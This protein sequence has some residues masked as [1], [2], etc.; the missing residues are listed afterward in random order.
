MT[1]AE[2][3]PQLKQAE[4]ANQRGQWRQAEAMARAYLESSGRDPQALMILGEALVGMRRAVEAERLLREAI[5]TSPGSGRARL[6]LGASLELQCRVDEAVELLDGLVKEQAG[7]AE[8]WQHFAQLLGRAFRF[9]LAIEAHKRVLRLEDKN[10]RLWLEYAIALRFAGRQADALS[11]LRRSLELDASYG[12]A[13]WVVATMAS[14]TVSAADVGQIERA[15][16]Q[17]RHDQISR[18]LHIALAT[19]LDRSGDH[20]RAYR[21]FAAGKAI[22]SVGARHDPE[23][24]ERYNS[25]A[26]ERFDKQFFDQRRGFGA[27]SDAPI[28]IVGLPRSGSTLVERILGG[29]SRIEAAGE[30]PIIPSLIDQLEAE[31]EKRVGYRDLLPNLTAARA[32]EL[33]E[34]YLERSKEYRTTDKPMFIDK[35]H[36]NWLHLAFIRL[37]LPNARIID[38]RRNALDCCW[39]NFK[40]IFTSGHPAADN[41]N[42]IGRFYRDY[43]RMMDYAAGWRE[44]AILGV[45]YEAL[46]EDI[47]GETRRMLAFL[48]LKF[49]SACLE[50]HRLASPVATQ[51]AEQVRRPLNDEGIGRWK[52]YRQWLGP[53]FDALGPLAV[54]DD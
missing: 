48:G 26:I 31:V 2:P 6:T 32:R 29:H 50:F 7:S 15:L 40:T 1:A 49:E 8:L 19:V 4:I 27:K 51:S 47:E 30:L 13:W 23:A 42:H 35:L 25:A 39:S 34:L 41:L 53:L 16:S 18:F 12:P 20:D 9:D 43:V 11:A 54:S 44:D 28:F 14:G 46:V 22:A 45:S 21:H 5:A 38:V 33:G 52:P 17:S 36:M 37:I 10:P 24:L 3:N